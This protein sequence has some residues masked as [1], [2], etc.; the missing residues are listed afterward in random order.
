MVTAALPVMNRENAREWEAFFL[1][2][3]G[4]AGT[5]YLYD[6]LVMEKR[7]AAK[8]A[9]VVDSISGKSLTVSGFAKN[10]VGQVEPGDWL[11]IGDRLYKATTRGSSDALGV[12]SFDVWPSVPSDVAM[13]TAI[14]LNAPRGEFRLTE[15]PEL[16]YRVDGL[17][18]GFEFVAASEV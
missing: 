2:L 3:N 11:Q 5:F 4:R 15:I 1:A 8:G 14:D 10:V 17:L 12:C 6:S 18:A 9:P 13:G 7:G 16:T